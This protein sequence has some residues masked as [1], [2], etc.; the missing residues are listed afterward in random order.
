ME[1]TIFG[2]FHARTGQADA[3]AAALREVVPQSR[4]EPG[5]VFI[6]AYRSVQ[7]A[8]LFHIHS[9][10]VDEA[11]FELHAGLAHTVAFLARVQPLI[12]HPLAI[13][14]ARPLDP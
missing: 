9:R 1:L 14:R 8:D 4:A 5:C 10:W 12:D 11:A 7:D 3:V 2:R 13:S 6:E